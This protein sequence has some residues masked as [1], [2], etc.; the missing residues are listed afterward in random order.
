MK[1]TYSEPTT[2][3]RL[4][5]PD[6]RVARAVTVPHGF[7]CTLV[8]WI[9]ETVEG[10]EEF[11]EWEKGIEDATTEACSSDALAT[12]KLQNRCGAEGLFYRRCC[13]LNA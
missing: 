8:W 2:L 1:I 12:I 4:H 11:E 13:C 3:W 5:H 10:A 9:N 7:R 6:G